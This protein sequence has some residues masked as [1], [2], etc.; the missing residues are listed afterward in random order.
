MAVGTEAG[1]HRIVTE[2]AVYPSLP[3]SP[4]DGLGLIF[5]INK[6]SWGIVFQLLKPTNL[7]GGLTKSRG[8]K[9]ALIAYNG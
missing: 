6:I 4:A 8:S 3:D 7:A 2:E 9:Q 5:L 1:C